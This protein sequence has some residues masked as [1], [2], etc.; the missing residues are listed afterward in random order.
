M[1]AT[2]PKVLSIGELHKLTR[3]PR[4]GSSGDDRE[5]ILR[6][7]GELWECLVE[8]V[9]SPTVSDQ[10]MTAACNALCFVVRANIQHQDEASKARAYDQKTW[11]QMFSAARAA[12]A[13]GKT[14]P[15]LQVLDTLHYLAEMSPYR[16]R[17]TQ[18]VEE[19]ATEMVTIILSHHPRRC[20]K[21]ACIVLYFFLRKLSD[22]MSFSDVL[23]QVLNHNKTAFVQ[24]CRDSGIRAVSLDGCAHPQWFAF[25]LALLLAVRITE[26][27]SATLKLLTLLCGLPMPT[28]GVDVP[29]ILSKSID[30]YSVA[31]EAA[32]EAVTRDVLPSVLTSQDVFA[33]FL[34]KQQSLGKS[35]ISAI[36][37]VLTL[38]QYG[39]S[40]SYVLESGKKPPLNLTMDS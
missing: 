7:A 25:V 39:K 15:A 30:V 5:K 18:N 40:R 13:S 9:R 20:I 23:Q 10:H 8:T 14:K 21:E 2:D 33:T 19:A 37:V 34:L 6:D 27:K 4:N 29:S 16:A 35:N 36:L 1:M 24:I 17:V 32:L 22:F 3:T 28:Y 38:L 12:F 26:S 11:Q 31:D